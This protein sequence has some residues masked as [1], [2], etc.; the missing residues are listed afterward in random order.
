M[1]E[2]KLVIMRK[3]LGDEVLECRIHVS[4]D[5][6]VLMEAVD[7]DD[8][9]IEFTDDALMQALEIAFAH[10]YREVR[11]IERGRGTTQIIGDDV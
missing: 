7:M 2:E 3:V 9:I 8:H 11:G 5:G 6:S 10:G 1:N 4:Y